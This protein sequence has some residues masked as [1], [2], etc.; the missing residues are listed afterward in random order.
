MFPS[1]AL[2]ARAGPPDV[3]KFIV[4]LPSSI[5]SGVAHVPLTCRSLAAH[6]PTAE[7][8]PPLACF[9]RLWRARQIYHSLDNCCLIWA[10][11]GPNSDEF[12]QMFRTV[13]EDAQLWA[14]SVNFCPGLAKIQQHLA[15]FDRFLVKFGPTLGSA[16][17]SMA[18]MCP[19]RPTLVD[20]GAGRARAFLVTVQSW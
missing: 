14:D 3:H 1:P 19:I 15:K 9:G 20:I 10:M 7:F 11:C 16:G 13:L 12:G 6:V 17:S 2:W 18:D 5:R 4:P 8:R